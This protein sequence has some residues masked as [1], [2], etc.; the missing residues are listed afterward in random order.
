MLNRSVGVCGVNAFCVMHLCK[1]LIIHFFALFAAI[2]DYF[3][4]AKFF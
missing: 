2:S 4:V 1:K 3:R